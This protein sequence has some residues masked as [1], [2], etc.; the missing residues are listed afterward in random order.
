MK[1]ISTHTWNH[2]WILLLLRKTDT[3]MEMCVTYISFVAKKITISFQN[4]F[5]RCGTRI[6]SQNLVHSVKDHP[7]LF[8]RPSILPL[9]MSCSKSGLV[10]LCSTRTVNLTTVFPGTCTEGLQSVPAH[11]Q[12]PTVFA[13]TNKNAWNHSR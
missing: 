10:L 11:C 9:F 3:H 12:G 5:P 4:L 1:Y 8:L 7:E 6:L 13:S 2:S